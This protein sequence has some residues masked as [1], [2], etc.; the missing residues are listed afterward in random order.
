MTPQTPGLA[1]QRQ[2]PQGRTITLPRSSKWHHPWTTNLFW[3]A[4]L[5]KWVASVRPGFVNGEAPV[6]KTSFAEIMEL[7]Q[8]GRNFGTNPL[9][10]E[11]YF[12]SYIFNQGEAKK[13]IELQAPVDVPLYFN[14]PISTSWR[15]LGVDG[16][17]STVP[18]FFLDR[19]VN[20]PP[21]L[22]DDESVAVQQLLNPVSPKQNRL[23]R[24]CDIVLH[25][26]RLALTSQI[27]VQP[28]I[29]TGISNVT[30]TL[31]V[32]SA[33]PG[34]RLK[35]YST[36]LFRPLDAAPDPLTGVYEEP[37]F[38][39]ILISTIYLLS[40]PNATPNSAPDATWTPF[41]RQALFWDL[42][43]MQ[44]ELRIIN[45]DPGT[46]FIPPLAA[47]AAQ[48]IINFTTASFNDAI[49]NALNVL[50]GHSL[51]GTFWTP[52]GGGSDSTFPLPSLDEEKPAIGTDKTA[53]NQ[54]KARLA[55][56]AKRRSRLDPPFPYIARAFDLALL[57]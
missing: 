23:L 42:N 1:P 21:R 46:P 6:V 17:G 28:G 45:T 53:R 8:A 43:Y 4:P 30:Q 2:H 38:D 56:K 33:A 13:K 29:V 34:D 5:K 9:T 41:V 49:S 52:T 24:A 16:P 14:P 26:P 12:S 36:S 3:L 31:S 51:A 18:Q 20:A 37:N 25:Q 40:P 32:R 22:S 11:P 10:G 50:S 44:P 39:E 54:A 7:R 15:N 35:V 55:Q 47:G 19:G 27:S 57:S 48:L